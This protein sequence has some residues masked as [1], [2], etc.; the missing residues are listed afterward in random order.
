MA[1]A[2]RATSRRSLCPRGCP[3]P[4]ASRPV[5]E[6][7]RMATSVS[8]SLPSFRLPLAPLQR[9]FRPIRAEF[10]SCRG[11]GGGNSNKLV[12]VDTRC[13][14]RDSWVC[15]CRAH[16][17]SSSLCLSLSVHIRVCNTHAHTQCDAHTHVHTHPPTHTHTH[18]HTHTLTGRRRRIGAGG[19][20]AE[21]CSLENQGHPVL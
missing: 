21:L 11:P 9:A 4:Q 19:C 18:T 12:Y 13:I 5:R 10:V 14:P 15:V 3:A 17:A 16:C 8:F 6:H 7:A 1:A 20:I 2:S